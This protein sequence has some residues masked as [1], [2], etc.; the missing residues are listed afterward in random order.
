MASLSIDKLTADGHEIYVRNKTN[1]RGVVIITLVDPRGRSDKVVIPKTLLPVNLTQLVPPDM[2]RG[3]PDLRKYIAKGT[4]EIV[5]PSVAEKE[6]ES[7]E[8]QEDLKYAMAEAERPGSMTCLL[9][10]P[11]WT[12]PVPRATCEWP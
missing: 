11:I 2:L 1:P 9:W 6:L 8:A 7:E 10:W 5:D 4:L 3:S 12:N